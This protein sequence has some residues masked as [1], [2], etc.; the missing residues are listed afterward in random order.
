MTH[1]QWNAKIRSSLALVAQ[2]PQRALEALDVTLSRVHSTRVKTV[3]D[4]HIDQTLE[5]RSI[6]QS[7]LRDHRASADTMLRVA[8]RHEEALSYYR[9]GFVAACAAAALELA[10]AGDRAEA[11]HAL[12][13]A[14]PVAEGLRPQE[15]LYR[16]AQTVVAR[17]PPSGRVRPRARRPGS[18]VG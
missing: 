2:Q 18:I 15:K 16:K 17:M 9:R 1:A 6:V 10:S 3:G 11:L 12:R 5:A 14:E 8:Q 13:K 4:W 7:H